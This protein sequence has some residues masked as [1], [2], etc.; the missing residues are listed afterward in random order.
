[1]YI[2]TLRYMSVYLGDHACLYVY[3]HL[4]SNM[5]VRY[6]IGNWV[7]VSH[8]LQLQIISLCQDVIKAFS[9]YTTG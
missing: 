5:Y 2:S 8:R 4:C 9:F 7:G 3:M 1:M 6:L